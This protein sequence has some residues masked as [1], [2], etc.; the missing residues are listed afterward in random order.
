MPGPRLV[1]VA[2]AA[3]VPAL[4]S[5]VVEPLAYQRSCIEAY[6]VSQI[7]RG[8]SQATMEN[9]PG[10]L[11][12][13]LAA[14]GCPAWEITREDVDRVVSGFAAQRL[15]SS[16]RRG[17]V[18]SFKMFH[19]FLRA[20]KSVEIEALFGVRLIDPLDEF[21]ASRHVGDDG[22]LGSAPATP[23]R[24]EVFFDFLKDRVGSARKYGVAGRDYALFR[25]LYLAGVRAEESSMLD[26]ADLHFGRGPFGK[27]HVRFGKGAKTSGPRPRWVPM[28]DELD[29]ILQWF[30]RD[31]RQ[32]RGQRPPEEHFTGG[33]G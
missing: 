9:G 17:Y 29:L 1:V 23:Q 10:V 5:P 22:A 20:R 26:V 31:I 11:E 2:G 19:A 27:I 32:G 14:A 25:T 33:G 8:F 18:Q 3:A 28:L 13:F 30:L 12:R 6:E 21:N 7:A 24:L 4:S 15:A 16:T